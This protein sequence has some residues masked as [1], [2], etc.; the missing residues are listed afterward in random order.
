MGANPRA[1]LLFTGQWGEKIKLQR[2]KGATDGEEI[3]WFG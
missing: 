1:D 2:D 3:A